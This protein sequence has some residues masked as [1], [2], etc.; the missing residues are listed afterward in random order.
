MRASRA[1]IFKKQA[2]AFKADHLRGLDGSECCA[3]ASVHIDRDGKRQSLGLDQNLLN[4]SSSIDIL[5]GKSQKQEKIQI[6]RTIPVKPLLEKTECRLPCKSG[7]VDEKYD[8]RFINEL[9]IQG[10]G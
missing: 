10:M 3:E 7:G 8:P 6:M 9:R 5:V 2:P 4:R 1:R